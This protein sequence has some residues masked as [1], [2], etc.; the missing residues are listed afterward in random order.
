MKKGVRNTIKRVLATSA[1]E[2][3]AWSFGKWKDEYV[4]AKA[5][6]NAVTRVRASLERRLLSTANERVSR[7]FALWKSVVEKMRDRERIKKR[8]WLAL[9]QKFMVM[10]HDQVNWAF[11]VLKNAFVDAKRRETQLKEDANLDE[12]A[13]GEDEDGYHSYCFSSRAEMDGE[14]H[15]SSN[16]YGHRSS[17]RGGKNS[18][19]HGYSDGYRATMKMNPGLK[20]RTPVLD[21]LCIKYGVR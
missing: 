21:E 12:T 2:K 6:C 8:V 3:M 19:R 18:S 4:E 7:G 11:Q 1:E 20:I 14:A 10:V 9:E 16:S 5:Q 15:G 13:V 17:S